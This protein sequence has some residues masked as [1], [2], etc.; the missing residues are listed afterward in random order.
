M[1]KF[2]GPYCAHGEVNLLAVGS[3]PKDIPAAPAHTDGRPIIGHSETG[4]LHVIEGN[5]VRVYEEDAFT[6]YIEANETATVVHLRAFDRHET[7]ELP[8]GKYR[9]TRQREHT[10]EGFR[11]AAD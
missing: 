2:I 7:I 11:R 6:S 8:P 9:V 10:P 5:A 4:A 1:K 3:I